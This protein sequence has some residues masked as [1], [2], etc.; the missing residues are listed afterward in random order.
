MLIKTLKLKE[1]ETIGKEDSK[2]LR[3]QGFIPCTLYGQ[4]KG[5][6]HLYGFVKDFRDVCFTPDVYKIN[7]LIE[8]EDPQEAII[9]ESQ[10]HPLS[11]DVLHLDFL[12]VQEDSEVKLTLPVSFEGTP[13]GVVNGGRL[14]K[15]IRSL[16]VKGQVQNI[17]EQLT[18]DVS[19]MD[20]GTIIKVQ[21][22]HFDN[23]KIMNNSSVAVA[24]VALPKKARK[25]ASS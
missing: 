13:A 18:I 6:R 11:D 21:D 2:R 15:K 16:Q 20:N 12:R 7:L 17:P 23:L 25:A 4:N 10:F 3:K 24:S 22:L 8:N 9:Q 14:F 1:R 19:G 5:I